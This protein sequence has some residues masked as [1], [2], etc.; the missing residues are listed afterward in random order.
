[1]RNDNL[2]GALL[3]LILSVIIAHGVIAIGSFLG[4]LL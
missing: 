3:L 4:G 1:M 2:G